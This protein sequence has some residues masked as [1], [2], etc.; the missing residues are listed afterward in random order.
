MA[1]SCQV[2]TRLLP[3]AIRSGVRANLYLMWICISRRVAPAVDKLDDYRHIIE[4]SYCDALV[5]GDDQLIR[6]TPRI[7]PALESLRTPEL[8]AGNVTSAG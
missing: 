1:V 7:N 6:T 4:A 3:P 2:G 5:S 8:L